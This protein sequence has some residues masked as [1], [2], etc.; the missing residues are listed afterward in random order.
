MA[1]EMINAAIVALMP[2]LVTGAIALFRLFMS[3]LPANR[4]AQAEQVA[5]VVVLAAEQMFAKLPGTSEEKKAEAVKMAQA[6]LSDLGV[7]VSADTLNA[8]IESAVHALQAQAP[9]K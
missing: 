7:K 1:Q 9:A 8:L 5:G 4:Q 2:F 3:K 6:M